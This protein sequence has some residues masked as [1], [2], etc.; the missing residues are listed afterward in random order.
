MPGK[1][2]LCFLSATQILSLLKDNV[3]IIEDYA[4]SLLHR[5]DQRDDIVKAWAYLD[6]QQILR[7]A[8]AL[9][10]VP[11]TQ[12]GPLHGLAIAIKDSIN[13]KAGWFPLPGKTTTPGLTWLNSGPQTAN[14]HDVN[15]TPGRS[16]TGSAA[17]AADFQVPFSIGTQT[18]GSI[19][20][21]AS[22]TGIF[23]MKPTYNAISLKGQKICSISLDTIGFFARYIEDLQL[24]TDAFSLKDIHPHKTIPLKEIRDQAGPG[25]ITA[26]NTAFTILH[27]RGIKIDQVAFPPEYANS[28][29]LAQNFNTIYETEARSSFRQE[30]NMDKSK[31]HPEIRTFVETPPPLHKNTLKLSTTS[32]ASEK[33]SL[34]PSSPNRRNSHPQ[35]PRRSTSRS[36]RYGK[37]GIQ[38]LLDSAYILSSLPTIP[39]LLLHPHPHLITSTNPIHVL[40][41][42]KST[43]MPVN[44][45]AFIGPTRMPIGLSLI[46][47]PF[48]DQHLL[49]LAKCIAE[50]LMSE[51]GCKGNSPPN[52]Q[53]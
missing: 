7:Q 37:F 51:G 40:Q 23:A 35:R 34:L 6:S 49:F 53:V 4:R 12:R 26:M 2:E 16:S 33:S 13:T 15:R 45:P 9:D 52:H 29:V 39:P 42:Q 18:S 47:S 8:R 27:N 36:T 28:K 14:L 46:A 5:I 48:R 38:F 10:R 25:T 11:P 17:V 50:P 41:S 21:P 44:I 22:Y 19:I 24:L 43:H 32:P 20:R 30:Y 3:I 1:A 31:L